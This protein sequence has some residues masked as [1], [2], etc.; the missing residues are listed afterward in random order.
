MN[1]V[2][3]AQLFVAGQDRFNIEQAKPCR[4]PD[5]AFNLHRIPDHLAEHLIAAANAKNSAATAI[6]RLDVNVPALFPEKCKIANGGFAAGQQDQIAHRN[7]GA[8][9]D[10]LDMHERFLTQR[11]KVVEIGNA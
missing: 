8:G 1:G 6:M 7:G 5:R 11:V 2:H 10:H 4:L 3:P 9:S